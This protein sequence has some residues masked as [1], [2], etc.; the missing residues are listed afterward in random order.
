MDRASHHIDP[1]TV[2]GERG[3]NYLTSIDFKCKFIDIGHIINL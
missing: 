3:Q 1:R 2:I